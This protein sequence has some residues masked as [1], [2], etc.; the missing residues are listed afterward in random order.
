MHSA[1]ECA[2]SPRGAAVKGSEVVLAVV[3]GP[4]NP[5]ASV[6]AASCLH[7]AA[8]DATYR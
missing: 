8:A 4:L 3:L 6:A 2:E 7:G 1:S 5:V